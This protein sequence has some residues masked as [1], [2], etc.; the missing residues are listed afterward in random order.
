MLGWVAGV[1]VCTLKKNGGRRE[2]VRKV[3]TL[4]QP[5]VRLLCLCKVRHLGQKVLQTIHPS[6][7][8]HPDDTHVVQEGRMSGL[9]AKILRFRREK[10]FANKI[11]GEVTVT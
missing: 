4:T 1:L 11:T 5:D 10:N 7:E 2:S 3:Y 8:Q 9:V 6:T